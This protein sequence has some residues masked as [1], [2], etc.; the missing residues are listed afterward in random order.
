MADTPQETP[1]GGS[2]RGWVEGRLGEEGG[3]EGG[4]VHVAHFSQSQ[5]FL[6]R[7]SN[8]HGHLKY[9]NVHT[10]S[11]FK[12]VADPGGGGGISPGL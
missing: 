8:F 6:G 4:Q 1:G 7:K 2:G 9:A 12:A 5:T 10:Y 3:L 11:L